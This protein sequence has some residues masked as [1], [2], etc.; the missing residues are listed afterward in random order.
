MKVNQFQEPALDC[1]PSL[2]QFFVIKSYTADDIHK[3]MKYGIWASTKTGNH[4]LDKAFKDANSTY[5]IYLFFSANSSGCFCGMAR[6]ETSLNYSSSFGGW[7][8]GD[9]WSGQFK[10]KWLIIKN[11]GNKRLK[12][13]RLSNNSNKPVTNSRDTQE[14]LYDQGCE[15]LNIFSTFEYSSSMLDEWSNFDRLEDEAKKKEERR[16]QSVKT[17]NS[18]SNTSAIPDATDSKT[19]VNNRGVRSRGSNRTSEKKS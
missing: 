16:K 5:P 8:Q 3:S 12:H 1:K 4:R 18:G 7:G 2:A 14:V 19:A 17:T 6:M 11:I 13:I 10:V 9:K 15:L